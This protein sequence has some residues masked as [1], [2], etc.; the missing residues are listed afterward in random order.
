[1]MTTTTTHTTHIRT[2]SRRTAT[3]RV[4]R[5][6]WQETEI[7]CCPPGRVA[8]IGDTPPITRSDPDSDGGLTPSLYQCGTCGLGHEAAVE[9]VRVS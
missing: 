2:V 8:R 5:V 4:W 7:T 1:M 3:P 6:T 9:I